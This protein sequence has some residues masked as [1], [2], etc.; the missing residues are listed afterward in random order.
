MNGLATKEGAGVKPFRT[1]G[2]L[3]L[4][5]VCPW[6]S[7]ELAANMLILLMKHATGNDARPISAKDCDYA[8]WMKSINRT[9]VDVIS[10]NVRPQ[11]LGMDD[12]INADTIQLT[13]GDRSWQRMK[14]RMQPFSPASLISKPVHTRMFSP[15][16]RGIRTAHVSFAR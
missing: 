12:R 8:A 13:T 5:N 7:R 3:V 2:E 10:Q 14:C 9:L 4:G 16:L 6:V 15:G 1:L 11:Q